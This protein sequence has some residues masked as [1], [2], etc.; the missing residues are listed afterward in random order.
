MCILAIF[1]FFNIVTILVFFS[2][3]S[4]SDTDIKEEVSKQDIAA[5]YITPPPRVKP[6]TI[7]SPNSPLNKFKQQKLLQAIHKNVHNRIRK[8]YTPQELH[9]LRHMYRNQPPNINIDTQLFHTLFNPQKNRSLINICNS[10]HRQKEQR[11]KQISVGKHTIGYLNYLRLIPWQ[12]RIPN[13]HP[14]TPKFNEM[15]ENEELLGKR[16]FSGKM[17]K[18][19]KEL[20]IYDHVRSVHQLS[21]QLLTVQQKNDRVQKQKKQIQKSKEFIIGGKYVHKQWMEKIEHKIN[22]NDSKIDDDLNDN[23][24]QFVS[25]NM[26]KCRMNKC[27]VKKN[28]FNDTNVMDVQVNDHVKEEVKDTVKKNSDS[29]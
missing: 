18:W 4:M 9:D 13:V 3:F 14:S 1:I 17:N 6:I 28:G 15:D 8:A 22:E 12:E 10:Y 5:G 24:I 20:H 2:Q 29:D 16:R 26:Y 27:W 19:R 21:W 7:Y 25:E 23:S 11:M